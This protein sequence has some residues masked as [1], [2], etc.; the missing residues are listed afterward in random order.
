MRGHI[1]EVHRRKWL[2]D[3]KKSTDKSS[4]AKFVNEDSNERSSSSSHYVQ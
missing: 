4:F 2:S 1:I 3:K